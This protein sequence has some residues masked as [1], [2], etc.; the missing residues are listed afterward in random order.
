LNNGDF[1]GDKNLL[2]HLGKCPECAAYAEAISVMTDAL[3]SEKEAH[4]TGATPMPL[5]RSRLE[6]LMKEKAKK[7]NSTMAAI[8]KQI[9]RRPRL[10][11][12]MG[13]AVTAF[14]FLTLVPFSYTK[15]IGYEVVFEGVDHAGM[16]PADRLENA[17][18]KL[19]FNDLSLDCRDD[20][21]RLALLPTRDRARMAAA[22]FKRLVEIDATPSVKAVTR[23]VSGSLYAQAL[24]KRRKIE[25]NTEGKSQAEI[26]NEI[27][28]KLM[29]AGF[30]N[31]V[32]TV[33][34]DADG[35]VKI[36]VSAESTSSDDS[37]E[38]VLELE[39]KSDSGVFDFETLDPESKIEIE[40]EGL[41][42]QEIEDKIK[43]KLAAEGKEGAKVEV[44][45]MPDG[46]R[47]IRVTFEEEVEK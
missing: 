10:I 17:L 3:A 16:M 21:C 2:E 44:T 46:R 19:G 29:D 25:I 6:S 18:S 8:K 45:T 43:A 4:D 41:T 31:P 14:L 12:G 28:Q 40:T 30:D 32:V 9:N 22:A 23:T 47:D 7:E 24:E 39:M 36:S 11:A 26:E 34:T 33:T 35:Q 15:T 27:R 1:E 37:T 38:K 20:Y 13:L 42:N 5:I